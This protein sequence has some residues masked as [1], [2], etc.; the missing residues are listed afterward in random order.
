MLVRPSSFGDTYNMY[1]LQQFN[2]KK[3]QIIS[4]SV[5]Y[6]HPCTKEINLMPYRRFLTHLNFKFFLLKMKKID[7]YG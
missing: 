4:I 2:L 5:K 3:E 1:K 7:N 6:N